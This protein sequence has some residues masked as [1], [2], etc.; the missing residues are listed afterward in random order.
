MSLNRVEGRLT[1]L[2]PGDFRDGAFPSSF[3]VR[4][5]FSHGFVAVT[6]FFQLSG[7]V[8]T[9]VN[10]ARGA[11]YDDVMWQRRFWQ[12]RLARLG[13]VYVLMLLCSLP[14][15]MVAW[16][17]IDV[18]PFETRLVRCVACFATALGVQTWDFSTPLWRLWNYPAWAVS[19]ELAFY[20]IFPFLVPFIKLAVMITTSLF[21]ESSASAAGWHVFGLLFALCVLGQLGTWYLIQFALEFAGSSSPLAADIAYTRCTSALFLVLVVGGRSCGS[22]AYITRYRFPPVRVFEFIQGILL[23]LA[24]AT[25]SNLAIFIQRETFQDTDERN[26]HWPHCLSRDQQRIA[27]LSDA[28]FLALAPVKLI[29]LD[30]ILNA[31]VLGISGP[32]T[33]CRRTPC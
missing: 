33:P 3:L 14:P 26:N 28:S 4:R 29:D 20:L 6:F 18:P 31:L 7:F 22:L 11:E 5:V 24:V 10:E 19:C 21:D 16:K 25:P 23:G 15:L 13:P 9:I 32:R 17:S 8:N 1:N 30:G 2:K 12:R 27:F